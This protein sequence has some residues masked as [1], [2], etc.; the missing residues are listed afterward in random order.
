MWH[1]LTFPGGTGKQLGELRHWQNWIGG[2]R[3]GNAALV[4][5][6]PQDVA[7]LL[8]DL[9]R[10]IHAP[11]TELPPLVRV[12]LTTPDSKLSTPSWTATGALGAC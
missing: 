1:T 8:A 12:A 7:D 11:D 5:P 10:F 6:P 3:P 2:A 4:P 9:E